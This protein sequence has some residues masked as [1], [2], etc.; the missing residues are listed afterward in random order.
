M[1]NYQKAQTIPE[2][3]MASTL[4]VSLAVAAEDH[5]NLLM[6][7]AFPA[8]L[9]KFRQ[10]HEASKRRTPEAEQPATGMTFTTPFTPATDS[11]SQPAATSE[12][13]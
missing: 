9:A 7:S 13:D 5:W 1:V 8:W 6:D 11:S 3:R 4:E 2:Y 12:T 10:R